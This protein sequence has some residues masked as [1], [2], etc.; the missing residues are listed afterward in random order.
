VDWSGL[1]EG[2]KGLGTDPGTIVM[3]VIGGVFI[4]LGSPRSLNPFSWLASALA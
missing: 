1:Y 4:Y 2:F 3:L